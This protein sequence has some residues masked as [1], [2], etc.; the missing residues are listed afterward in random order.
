MIASTGCKFDKS[1]RN[2]AKKAARPT[3]RAS[4]GC[5]A[6]T[7]ADRTPPRRIPN[8]PKDSPER[9]VRRVMPSTVTMADPLVKT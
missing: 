4:R 7:V 6:V 1:L 5:I 9:M 2:T 3:R 8:S